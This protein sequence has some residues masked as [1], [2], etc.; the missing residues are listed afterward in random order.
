MGISSDLAAKSGAAHSERFTSV[1]SSS[2]HSSSLFRIKQKS[3][4][5]SVFDLLLLLLVIAGTDVQTNEEVAIKLVSVFILLFYFKTPNF[6]YSSFF[7]SYKVDS[8]FLN[9]RKV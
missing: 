1:P 8:F 4:T 9:C 2:P 6:S 3:S 5:L 7:S